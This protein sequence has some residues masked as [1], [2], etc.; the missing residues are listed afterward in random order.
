MSGNL[1]AQ[2]AAAGVQPPIGAFVQ[3]AVHPN[4]ATNFIG[5]NPE[6]AYV[7]NEAG[8]VIGS[9]CETNY[10]T[11]LTS[12]GSKAATYCSSAVVLIPTDKVTISSGVA[13]KDNSTGTHTVFADVPAGGYFW[14]V[15]N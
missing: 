14:A 6:I 7:S 9:G 10:G 5:C 4:G 2:I 1:G 13:T 8:I 3:D 12:T 15:V 11:A